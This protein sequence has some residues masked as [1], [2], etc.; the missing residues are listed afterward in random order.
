MSRENLSCSYLV[1]FD[2]HDTGEPFGFM[3]ARVSGRERWWLVQVWADDD[4]EETIRLRF[5]AQEGPGAEV[6]APAA[7][8]AGRPWYPIP[9]ISDEVPRGHAPAVRLTLDMPRGIRITK[10]W[11]PGAIDEAG[12]HTV[13]RM[14][15]VAFG[16]HVD[17]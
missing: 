8:F 13:L 4:P 5:L 12:R 14:L 3:R 1:P 15:E 10:E 7:Q 16:G 2:P 6:T 11:G 17:A 9:W